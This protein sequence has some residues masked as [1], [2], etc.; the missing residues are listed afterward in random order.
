MFLLFP[1]GLSQQWSRGSTRQ[2]PLAHLLILVALVLFIHLPGDG[3]WKKTKKA[4]AED[5][6]QKVD[7]VA[8]VIFPSIV[9]AHPH[10][11]EGQK[12]EEFEIFSTR[13]PNWARK[14]GEMHLVVEH[15]AMTVEMS[16]APR[17][18][19][20]SHPSSVPKVGGSEEIGTLYLKSRKFIM[21]PAEQHSPV[22]GGL[23]G[24]ARHSAPDPL[25]PSVHGQAGR[26]TAHTPTP[27]PA[28]TWQI[29]EITAG[30]I[31]KLPKGFKATY[32]GW[33]RTRCRSGRSQ[34]KVAR[35]THPR[36]TISSS[37][38]AL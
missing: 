20:R 35:C 5:P 4:P 9:V 19:A 3:A 15:E 34:R 24:A 26:A 7:S 14:P 33:R 31:D 23:D 38:L 18:T 36:R 27:T 22:A 2:Y 11:Q 32:R 21:E 28:H 1:S 12:G 10:G 13:K 29:Y 16:K 30:Q 6:W 17:P 8:I 37:V 25:H